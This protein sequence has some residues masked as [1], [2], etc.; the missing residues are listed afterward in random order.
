MGQQVF[1]GDSISSKNRSVT[2][3]EI[4]VIPCCSESFD[5]FSN[6]KYNKNALE[7]ERFV[8]DDEEDNG[9]DDKEGA[10]EDE[11]RR[12]IKLLAKEVGRMDPKLS[13][14]I[15]RSKDPTNVNPEFGS[16]V[17]GGGDEVSVSGED[18][19]KGLSNGEI[20]LG[21]SS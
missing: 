4:S 14:W 2:Y 11:N 12:F 9:G 1:G 10:E 21:C 7:S 6:I 3:L 19:D 18:A 15:G 5:M 13:A 17:A 20:F 16:S 8:V